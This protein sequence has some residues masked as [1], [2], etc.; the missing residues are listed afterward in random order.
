VLLGVGL[1]LGLSTILVA[2]FLLGRSSAPSAGG[3]SRLPNPDDATSYYTT[4]GTEPALFPDCN[5]VLGLCLGN[6]VARALDMF[7]REDERYEGRPRG[8]IIR[9]WEVHGM[10]LTVDADR[11]ES[12]TAVTVAIGEDPPPGLRVGLVAAHPYSPI[13]MQLGQL[14][15]GAV[16]R[17]LGEPSDKHSTVAEN[18]GFSTYSYRA[19]PEATEK[20]SFTN[21]TLGEDYGFTPALDRQLVTSYSVERA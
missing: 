11:A 14:K 19:G 15:M 12:I 8:T 5:G 13:E 20:L 10:A 16:V 6:P 1:T 21:A 7:G 9:R 18:V 17:A 2:A 4:D 3:E